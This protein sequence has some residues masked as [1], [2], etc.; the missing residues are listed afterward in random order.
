MRCV[1]H[2][3]AKIC[4]SNSHLSSLISDLMIDITPFKY[5]LWLRSSDSASCYNIHICCILW[6]TRNQSLVVVWISRGNDCTFYHFWPCIVTD[7]CVVHETNLFIWMFSE[8]KQ[9]KILLCFWVKFIC[10]H[11]N[12]STCRSINR[13]RIRFYLSRIFAWS[14]RMTKC[15]LN[16]SGR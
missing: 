9:M 1:Y 11:C 7:K 5:K 15:E 14:E 6:W 2:F 13:F 3:E 4:C 12:G 8:W 10:W 16:V